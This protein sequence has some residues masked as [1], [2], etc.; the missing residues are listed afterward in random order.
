MTNVGTLSSTDTEVGINRANEDMIWIGQH[1]DVGTLFKRYARLRE[2]FGLQAIR[3]A[4]SIGISESSLS[5]IFN[6]HNK[7]IRSTLIAIDVAL[8]EWEK[9]FSVESEGVDEF[10]RQCHPTARATCP[11]SVDLHP[12]QSSTIPHLRARD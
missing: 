3:L 10:Q 7:P 8:N 5:R 2:E 11:A 4:Y 6:K 1:L 12:S 9:L